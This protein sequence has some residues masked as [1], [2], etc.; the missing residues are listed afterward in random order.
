MSGTPGMEILNHTFDVPNVDNATIDIILHFTPESNQTIEVTNTITR[1]FGTPIATFIANSQSFSYTDGLD[2]A[3]GG[4]YDLQ[5]FFGAAQ[6]N[7]F[8]T[9]LSANLQQS[10][11]CFIP[12]LS[13]LAIDNEDNWFASVDIPATHNSPFDAWYVPDVNEDHVTPT[14]ANMAFVLPE[15]RNGVNG[16]EQLDFDSV[17]RLKSNPISDELT[18]FTLNSY[19]QVEVSVIAVT[20]QELVKKKVVNVENQISLPINLSNGIYFLK[21]QVEGKIYLKKIIV[22]K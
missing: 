1:Y 13:A 14:T 16:I 7:D 18:I 15:I 19:V 11:F 9:E 22:S 20:G 17:F 10:D 21:L 8:L 5:A 4:K 2:S 6:G 12:T 3:P